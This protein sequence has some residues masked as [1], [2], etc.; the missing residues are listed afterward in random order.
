MRSK[1]SKV[2]GFKGANLLCE[3]QLISIF[4]ATLSVLYPQRHRDEEQGLSFQNCVHAT[5]G[6]PRRNYLRRRMNKTSTHYL[7]ILT[8]CCAVLFARPES[9]CRSK[10]PEISMPEPV[11][12]ASTA[13]SASTSSA[14]T[15]RDRLARGLARLLIH[16]FY[17]EVEVVGAE[18][19]RRQGARAGPG[20]QPGRQACAHVGA[21]DRARMPACRLRGGCLFSAW[22]LRATPRSSLRR[23]P[24]R[25]RDP[26]GEWDQ[27]AC[28]RKRGRQAGRGP[29]HSRPAFGRGA[30][31]PSHFLRRCTADVARRAGV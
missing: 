2:Q 1:I 7:S 30:A 6:I 25:A 21:P 5:A 31:D 15:L 8:A 18:R 3:S 4:E 29:S 11:V 14:A 28:T 17:R 20:A 12:R 26:G 24:A 13:L 22:R 16:V 23:V 27:N 10:I 19:V 9:T